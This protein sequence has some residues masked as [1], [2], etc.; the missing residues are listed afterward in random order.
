MIMLALLIG[1]VYNAFSQANIELK[2][3]IPGDIPFGRTVVLTPMAQIEGHSLL[4]GFPFSTVSEIQI[5]DESSDEMVYSEQF[6]ASGLVIVDLSNLL[7][8]TYM[9]R[10]YAFGKWWWGEFEIE[11][12]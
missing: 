10:L 2:E 1:L 11:I 12:M 5:I 7:A 9:V 4:V 6:G 8:G 3:D